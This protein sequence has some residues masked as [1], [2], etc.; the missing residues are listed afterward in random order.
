VGT[1][2]LEFH[3]HGYGY[4]YY[5]VS[6]SNNFMGIDI[7]YPYSSFDGHMTCGPEHPM[8][9]SQVARSQW[10]A[11]WG[12][13]LLHGVWDSRGVFGYRIARTETS[14]SVLFRPSNFER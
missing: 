9:A 8:D 2:M 14:P 13:S 12:F 11:S 7:C 10:P 4:K 3:I 6:T 5:I 1:D